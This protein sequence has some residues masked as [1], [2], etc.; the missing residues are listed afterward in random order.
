MS[1]VLDDVMRFVR[2]FKP[3]PRPR[4]IVG[5]PGI[6]DDS[7][8]KR[9]ADGLLL[10]G[11]SAW[12]AV[13]RAVSTAVVPPMSQPCGITTLTG[14]EIE[15]FGDRADHAALMREIHEAMV[16]GALLRV[17]LDSE[18]GDTMPLMEEARI[19]APRRDR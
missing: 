18:F 19:V 1:D 2:E 3:M 17:A 8:W 7:I 5:M 6:P 13:R 15:F 4:I 10:I 14:I 12:E 11:R 16:R 9:E